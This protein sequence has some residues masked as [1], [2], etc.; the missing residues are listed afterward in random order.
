M[1]SGSTVV[2]ATDQTLMQLATQCG[3]YMVAIIIM[4]SPVAPVAMLGSSC[5]IVDLKQLAVCT[6]TH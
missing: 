1:T 4:L 2:S 3:G 5:S 6:N